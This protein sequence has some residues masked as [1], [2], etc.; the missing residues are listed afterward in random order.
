MPAPTIHPDIAA[1]LDAIPAPLLSQSGKVFYTGRGAFSG[2]NKLYI[3]G[4]NP[5]GDP[6]AQAAET[7]GASL[8]QF[9]LGPAWWSDYA[10][11][12]WCGAA[13]GTWGMQPRVLHMLG[14]LGLDPRSV[15]ASNVL[16][17]RSSTEET[18]QGEKGL[19]LRD[20]WPVHRKVIDALSIGVLLCFGNTAGRWVREELRASE[21]VDGY[22]ESNGRKWSSVAHRAADGR[23]VITLTHPGRANWCN[24]NSDPTALVRR[25]LAQL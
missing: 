24:P 18:L 8:Q 10:D 3:L 9:R 2:P 6:E 13:P 15:P 12:S 11:E 20:C 21:F 16:F 17:V 4:L 5:G 19:L 25:T 22:Q 1:A 7:I 23:T 14:S